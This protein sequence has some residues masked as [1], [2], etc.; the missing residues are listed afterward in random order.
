MAKM[1]ALEK[2]EKQRAK[3]IYEYFKKI[4][5]E[6]GSVKLDEFTEDFLK[7]YGYEL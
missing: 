4:Q 5:K 7:K 2:K 1:T 3:K 6:G